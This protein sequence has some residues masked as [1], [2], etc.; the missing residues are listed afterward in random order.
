MSLV[1]SVNGD[2]VPR[3][4]PVLVRRTNAMHANTTEVKHRH[5]KRWI[6]TKD[7]N[8]N[9]TVARTAKLDGRRIGR[10]LV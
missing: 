1:V 2:H 5:G 8:T 6:A 3:Q 9:R 10:S 4:N 7:P